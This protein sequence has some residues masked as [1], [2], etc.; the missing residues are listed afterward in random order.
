MHHQQIPPA[1]NVKRNSSEREWLGNLDLRK[2]G[3]S[4]W[5]GM[6]EDKIKV[7][8]L[9]HPNI[10][11]WTGCMTVFSGISLPSQWK[12]VDW[13]SKERARNYQ[14]NQKTGEK[15]KY[16]W[17]S[18]VGKEKKPHPAI[19]S[20]ATLPTCP[21][22][23]LLL[24][25]GHLPRA[26]MHFLMNHGGVLVPSTSEHQ[27][28]MTHPQNGQQGYMLQWP[29]KYQ[30]VR[31]N[32]SPSFFPPPL[33]IEDVANG[34]PWTLSEEELVGTD[35]TMNLKHEQ[36]IKLCCLKLQGFFLFFF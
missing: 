22:L 1:K 17:L 32:V 16:L 11:G 10:Q 25:W 31:A 15:I 30:Y 26:S 29:I 33:V 2:K 8:F 27:G 3:R 19:K 13:M 18:W 6:N 12:G 20:L 36:E 34:E 9:I 7:L 23:S 24:F 14:E 35:P 21:F 4:L 5:E 28:T